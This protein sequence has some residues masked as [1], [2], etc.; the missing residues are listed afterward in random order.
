MNIL[1]GDRGDIRRS[2]TRPYHS[3]TENWIIPT[4]PDLIACATS[5]STL[6]LSMII[7][8]RHRF[9][10]RFHREIIESGIDSWYSSPVHFNRTNL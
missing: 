8:F 5:F 9:A 7:V 3:L 10:V 2:P 4:A 1:H 6:H